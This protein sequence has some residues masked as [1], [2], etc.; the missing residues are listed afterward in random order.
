MRYVTVEAS[1]GVR[2][3]TLSSGGADRAAVVFV[4]G[5]SASAEQFRREVIVYGDRYRT[6]TVSLRGHGEST[7]PTD[8]DAADFTIS[9]LA[10]DIVAV[11]DHHGVARAHLVGNSLGGLIGL[12][13]ARRQPDRL[14]SLVTF[15]SP[16]HMQM[17]ENA[18][19]A[20][21]GI[22]EGMGKRVMAAAVAAQT[23]PGWGRTRLREAVRQ[24]DM[25]ALTL[26]GGG[27]GQIDYRDVLASPPV[28]W[29][30]VRPGRDRPVNRINDRLLAAT[31]PGDGVEVADLPRAG[32]FANLDDPEGF[33]AVVRPVL[34]A[35]EG[36]GGPRPAP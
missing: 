21:L 34:A 17:S 10:S 1:S 11:L 35:V 32:H 18:L 29:L 27:L 4:H 25:R 2:L 26:A 16:L 5:L 8:A 30:L 12:D 23:R 3:S 22:W 33:D 20:I 9:A 28:P 31:P 24:A 15:G 7:L 19:L 13:L 14:L 36:A 6:L